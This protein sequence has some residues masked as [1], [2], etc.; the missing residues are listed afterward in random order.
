MATAGGREGVLDMLDVRNPCVGRPGEADDVEAG[1]VFEQAVGLEIGQCGAS[2]SRLA[3]GIDRLSRLAGRI[4]SAG[5]DFDKDDGPAGGSAVVDGDNVEFANAKI[6]LAADDL[7]AET[8]QI[9]DG[10][11]FAALAER[12]RKQ[13]AGEPGAQ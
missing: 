6:D 13:P 10:K 3:L 7:V 5:F 4:A 2:K 12:F 1:P 8:L 11:I 9:A